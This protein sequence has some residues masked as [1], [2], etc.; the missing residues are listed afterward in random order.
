MESQNREPTGTGS[1]STLKERFKK[2][3]RILRSMGC[4]VLLISALP[5]GLVCA[6]AAFLGAALFTS[7]VPLLIL[8]S[9]TALVLLT[10]GLSWLAVRCISC[11]QGMRRW[12]PRGLTLATLSVTMI[13]AGVFVFL[14]MNFPYDPQEP[15][16]GTRYWEL[17]T[18]SRVAYALTP[19]ESTPRAT[20]VVLLHGGP[21]VPYSLQPD[22]LDRM[23][24]GE[25][26][27]VYRYHQVGAG[28]SE[29]LEDARRYTLDRHVADLEALRM[30]IGAERVILIG[31]SWGGTLAA[32]YMADHQNRV[33]K[34]VFESPGAI[35]SPAFASAEGEGVLGGMPPRFYVVS[36]L[37]LVNPQAAHNL[38]PDH[39]MDG[40]LQA[41]V[42]DV[43]SGSGCGP[44][45][46]DST[47]RPEGVG[48]YTNVATNFDALRV[49]DPRPDLKESRTPALVLR[50]ECDYIGWEITRE[51]RDVLPES[52]MLYVE[53]AGHLI[54]SDR[55]EL[56]IEAVRSFLFDEPLPLKP[57]AAEEPPDR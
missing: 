40:A 13:L 17:S 42:G 7:T 55:P 9:A 26:F 5:L 56:Y 12:L 18:G 43:L 29:R 31:G 10:G 16:P 48:Y 22:R 39:E 44:E 38:A 52:T 47:P 20:P 23:L 46:R 15:T 35:W 53:D 28:L 33:E 41:V 21:G 51:Y 57:Y 45:R 34:V 3:L 2:S 50:G 11:R 8:A 54:D 27:D 4:W 32:N 49:A 30:E 36:A 19:A 6:V 14:P 1:T 25:G 24:A 37:A